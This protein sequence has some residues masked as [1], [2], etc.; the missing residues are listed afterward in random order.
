MSRPDPDPRVYTDA[1]IESTALSLD[2]LGKMSGLGPGNMYER[3]AMILRSIKSDRERFAKAVRMM[4]KGPTVGDRMDGRRS[5]Y[6]SNDFAPRSPSMTAIWEGRLKE[7][8]RIAGVHV[9]PRPEFV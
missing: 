5:Q 3:A 1:E 9:D 6:T 4:R 8:E 7:L 2:G